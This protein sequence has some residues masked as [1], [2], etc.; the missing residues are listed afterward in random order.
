MKQVLVTLLIVLFFA[1]TGF[2]R[3][4]S[5]AVTSD[6]AVFLP[7]AGE[8]GVDFFVDKVDG[9]KT[10]FGLYDSVV[11]DAGTRT[12]DIRLE[13][14]PAAGS[15]LLV[16]GLGNLFLR[17][18]TNKTFR[19][20]MEVDVEGGKTYQMMATADGNLLEIFV[21]DRIDQEVVTSQRFQLKDG[22][23]ERLF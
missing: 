15:S 17:A 9:N 6:T 14:T 7:I 16:G 12:L 20:Q 21:V 1:Q 5:I 11:V 10:R 4:R 13:Y 23:F 18:V 19:T 22:K 2:A 3:E 8:W